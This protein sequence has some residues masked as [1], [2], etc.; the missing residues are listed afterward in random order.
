MFMFGRCFK[1]ETM[2]IVYSVSVLTHTCSSSTSYGLVLHTINQQ[3]L[4]CK[5][6][7][8]EPCVLSKTD[9]L[10]SMVQST[11]NSMYFFNGLAWGSWGCFTSYLGRA[12][13]VLT[14]WLKAA[15]WLVRACEAFQMKGGTSWVASVQLPLRSIFRITMIC[16]TKNSD[17][18]TLYLEYLLVF[19]CCV[20]WFLL[21]T[22]W[23]FRFVGSWQGI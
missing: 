2:Y 16:M 17:I 20:I 7:A 18:K 4:C 19:L 3:Q 1:W 5:I 6:L 21:N 12:W 13:T 9:D 14:N 8:M 22:L 23:Y 10:W 15:G 11:T